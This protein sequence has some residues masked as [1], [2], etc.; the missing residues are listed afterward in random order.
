M[1][2]AIWI[3]LLEPDVLVFLLPIILG[4]IAVTAGITV[5][6]VKMVIAHRERVIMIQHGIHPDYPPDIKHEG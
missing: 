5:K 2:N 6:I 1:D 3:R 4:S